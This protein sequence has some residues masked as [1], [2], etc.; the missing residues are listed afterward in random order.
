MK[1]RLVRGTNVG[2]VLRALRSHRRIR[3]LPEL[4]DWEQDLLR[5]RVAP[6]TWYSLKVFDSLLQIVHRFVFDGSESAAQNMGR[7]HARTR[8]D[9]LPDLL[10]VTDQPLESL[11]RF[12]AS[13]REQYNF[14]EVA[15]TP[16]ALHDDEHG[17]RIRITGYPDMSACHGHAI[18]GFT[19]ELVERAGARVPALQ[20]E[21][22]PWMHN[23]VL[24]YA[25]RWTQ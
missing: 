21:E 25:L 20:I 19:L 11:S 12:A 23:N 2:S 17:A 14:G 16:L 4:G 10:L 3:P 7:A 5:K 1:E 8:L 9:A 18:I 6:S 15:V 24:S 13:W 22:R